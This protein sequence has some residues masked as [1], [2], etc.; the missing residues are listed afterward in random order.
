MRRYWV[1]DKTISG[2]FVEFKEDLFHHIFD[3]CRQ[4]VGSK[5]EILPGDGFA[6]LVEVKEKAKKSARGR[7]FER[8]PIEALKR[9]WI[10]LVLSLPKFQTFETILEK[11]TELG[12]KSFWPIT[13]DYSFV[14]SAEPVSA[15]KKERWQK[16]VISAT[17]QCGRGELLELHNLQSLE[18]FFK[19]PGRSTFNPESQQ[20]GLFCYEGQHPESRELG[21]WLIQEKERKSLPRD[22]WLFV[23][24]E[25]GWSSRELDF[26]LAQNLSPV[27]LG[28]QVLRVETACLTL[29]SILKYEF[30]LMR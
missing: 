23:G 10:H 17:Q 6:Y 28:P 16:I 27:S 2:E 8:R 19:N 7:I 15:N 1:G 9:P 24:S 20:L 14:R 29:V 22:L 11:I 13:S 26:F 21:D 4:E 25:G 18:S 3:V 12:V 30:D 5:F